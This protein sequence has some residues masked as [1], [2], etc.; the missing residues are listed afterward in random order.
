MI[1]AQRDL[2]DFKLEPV[3]TLKYECPEPMR[4]SQDELRC[5]LCGVL[6]GTDEPRPPCHTP[7]TSQG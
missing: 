4:H 7:L 6:W 1:P 2:F 3:D 5:R